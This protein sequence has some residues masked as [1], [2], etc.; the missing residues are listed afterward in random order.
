MD[1]FTAP[2]ANMVLLQDASLFSAFAQAMLY[3][4]S[5]R[6]AMRFIDLLQIPRFL[7]PDVHSNDVDP[8]REPSQTP[9]ES[10]HD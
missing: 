1:S 10:R 2:F 8:P 7:R 5:P 6:R 3:G 4:K 9:A